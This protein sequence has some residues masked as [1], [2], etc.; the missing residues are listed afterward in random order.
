MTKTVSVQKVT[1]AVG[2]VKIVTADVDITEYTA[3][4][5]PLAASDLG[6]K[7]L[8][9]LVVSPNE[10]FQYIVSYDYTGEKIR[11]VVPN[12]GVEVAGAV[13]VGVLRAVAVG[14]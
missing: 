10:N 12:T 11:A 3:L 2:P 6:M 5:E 8:D 7:R 13:D 1:R 9:S 14:V 4:G